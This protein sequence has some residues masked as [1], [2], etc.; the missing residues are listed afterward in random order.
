M[1][2]CIAAKF[3]S[4]PTF[5]SIFFFPL[6]PFFFFFFN[7]AVFL[8][9]L[10]R[11]RGRINM[12][13]EC[14]GLVRMQSSLAFPALIISLHVSRCLSARLWSIYPLCSPSLLISRLLMKA[15]VQRRR[16]SEWGRG[17]TERSDRG[18]VLDQLS[19]CQNTSVRLP[20]G[21]SSPLMWVPQWAPRKDHNIAF[22]LWVSLSCSIK[23]VSA[24]DRETAIMDEREIN[25][26]FL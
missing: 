3:E 4:R 15:L 10:P 22:A 6:P 11:P 23:N 19:V 5:P 20:L 25:Y 24:A 7:E 13:S 16:A 1:F 26:M 21:L 17:G 8:V 14:G 9:L 2:P 12:Q 18:G